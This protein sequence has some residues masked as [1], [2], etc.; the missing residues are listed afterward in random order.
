MIS[1]EGLL[2]VG[3]GLNNVS[4]NVLNDNMHNPLILLKIHYVSY[5][6]IVHQY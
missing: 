3:G 6:K 5:R 1:T 2:H 4:F